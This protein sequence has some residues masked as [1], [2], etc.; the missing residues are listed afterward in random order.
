MDNSQ[1]EWSCSSDV[2]SFGTA[3]WELTGLCQQRPWQSMGEP[4]LLASV[5]QRYQQAGSSSSSSSSPE[6]SLNSSTASGAALLPP[7]TLPRPAHCPLELYRLMGQCWHQEPG[8]RPTFRDIHA[9]LQRNS[10][11]P[12]TP[13]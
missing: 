12:S 5:I 8:G 13:M 6:T 7:E 10:K 9:F 1:D 2:Y 11:H 4:Q 3:L